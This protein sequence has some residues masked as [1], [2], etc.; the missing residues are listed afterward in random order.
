MRGS[1]ETVGKGMSGAVSADTERSK[2]ASELARDVSL[3]M[4][5]H[6]S[7]GVVLLTRLGLQCRE[8]CVPWQ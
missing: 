3:V 2:K 8:S 5:A 7:Y 6:D 4:H 1:D